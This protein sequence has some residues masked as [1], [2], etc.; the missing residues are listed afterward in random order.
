[1]GWTPTRSVSRTAII[2]AQGPI[3]H[4]VNHFSRRAHRITRIGTNANGIP[5]TETENGSAPDT[6]TIAIP[7]SLASNARL[8]LHLQPSFHCTLG[9]R[10]D[11]SRLAP[12]HKARRSGRSSKLL[13]PGDGSELRDGV[14]RQGQHWACAISLWRFRLPT[15]ASVVGGGL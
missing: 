13:T 9:L 4:L 2:S 5:A 8:L 10:L 15:A 7:R 6:I 14:L 3:A 12:P 1:M 11:G